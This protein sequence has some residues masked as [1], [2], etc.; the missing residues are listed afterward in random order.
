MANK[1]VDILALLRD[2]NTED[3]RDV[4]RADE[5]RCH[6]EHKHFAVFGVCKRNVESWIC[7][8]P[9]WI[10]NE[11]ANKL[12]DFSGGWTQKDIFASAI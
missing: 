1:N 4:L 7:C 12:V 9:H 10:A 2:S 8:D 5:K 11:T 6:V 3:W